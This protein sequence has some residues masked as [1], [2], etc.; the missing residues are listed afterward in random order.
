MI[1]QFD[2]ICDMTRTYSGIFESKAYGIL[3]KIWAKILVKI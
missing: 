1:T 2:Y 3:L